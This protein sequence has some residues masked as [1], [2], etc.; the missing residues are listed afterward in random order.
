[1]PLFKYSADLSTLPEDELQKTYD[2][3]NDWAFTGLSATKT[4]KVYEFFL[5]ERDLECL[6]SLPQHLLRCLS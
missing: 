5:E 3:L 1:M 6:K 4:P 2:Y